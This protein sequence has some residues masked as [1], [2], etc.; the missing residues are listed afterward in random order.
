[1][2]EYKQRAGVT[3]EHER[4]KGE[5]EADKCLWRLLKRAVESRRRPDSM[6]QPLPV[7]LSFK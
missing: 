7:V 2:K 4:D 1:M 3:E 5:M 6:L